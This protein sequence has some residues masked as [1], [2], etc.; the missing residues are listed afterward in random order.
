[1]LYFQVCSPFCHHW[2][3]AILCLFDL[4]SDKL[5]LSDVPALNTSVSL[6]THLKRLSDMPLIGFVLNKLVWFFWN[7]NLVNNKD[8]KIKEN[9]L[10][11][12]SHRLILITPLPTHL[13]GR[14]TVSIS[15]GLHQFGHYNLADTSCL[16]IHW[17]L[18]SQGCSSRPN[19]QKN[20][21][22]LKSAFLT[23][24]TW[25]LAFL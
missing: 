21:D 11:W 20:H 2:L 17:I 7:S 5:R 23:K 14:K 4:E 8:H 18:N 19:N 13:S 16:S 25:N 9:L 12:C 1:M 3:M 10:A 24:K 6:S 15:L 22:S